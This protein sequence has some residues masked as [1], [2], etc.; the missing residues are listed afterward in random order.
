[1]IPEK[2]HLVPSPGK[3]L[4]EKVESEKEAPIILEEEDGDRTVIIG[5][6][7]A[8]GVEHSR[9]TVKTAPSS[10]NA[11]TTVEW[12]P[13]LVKEN[14]LVLFYKHHDFVIEVE[15]MGRTIYIMSPDVI[16]ACIKEGDRQPAKPIKPKTKN[17]P[18]EELS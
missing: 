12:V 7:I 15:E 2:Y 6:V 14:D 3:V 8:V 4:V 11:E 5:R 1:M 9:K 10:V 18:F 17:I 13:L 16:L